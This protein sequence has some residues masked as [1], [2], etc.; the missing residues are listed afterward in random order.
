M[1]ER[2]AVQSLVTSRG[3]DR[4]RSSQ[5]KADPSSQASSFAI[6]GAGTA[7]C[8]LASL[9]TQNSVTWND[10]TQSTID[11]M[12]GVDVRPL[13]MT[14]MTVLGRV[15]SGCF[16]GALAIKTM[17]VSSVPGATQCLLSGVRSA[18]ANISLSLLRLF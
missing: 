16:E 13:G 9:S 18:N 7:S 15:S 14:T 17:D 11:F 5:S 6:T 2:G 3:V 1:A 12:G 8:L 4:G 10:D